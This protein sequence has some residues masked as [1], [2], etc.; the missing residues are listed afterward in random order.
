MGEDQRRLVLPIALIEA[1][2]N[3]HSVGDGMQQALDY[4]ETLNV[5]YVFSSNGD[6]F[7]FHDRTGASS[8]RETNLGLEDFPSPSDLWERFRVWKGLDAAS[9]EIVLQ[10]YTTTA[11]V[12]SR[13]TIR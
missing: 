7:V 4:A 5:P 13:A 2:D 12:R 9:E 11:A 8:P 1:K 3:S 6:G 10:D